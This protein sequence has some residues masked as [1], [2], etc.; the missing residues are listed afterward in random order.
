ML[1]FTRANFALFAVPK[2]G[3]TAYHAALERHAQIVLARDTGL[4]HMPLRKYDRWF[5]PY[6]KGAHDL[7]PD[8]VAVMRDPVEQVRSWYRFRLRPKVRGGPR[9][10]TG[11]SFDDFV[12]DVIARRPPEHARIGSQYTFLSSPKGAVLV[13]HLFAYEH[14]DRFRAFLKDRLGKEIDPPRRNV[15]PE[16][17]APLSDEMHAAFRAARPEEWALYEALVAAGGHLVT[18]AAQTA[19]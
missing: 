5:A 18:G 3:T 6:L 10:L 11:M 8:R 19:G 14:P 2:T 15:S 13:D 12:G 16:V 4:K 9:D 7:V 1:V 17:D